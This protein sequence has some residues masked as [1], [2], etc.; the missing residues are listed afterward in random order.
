M[1]RTERIHVYHQ[2]PCQKWLSPGCHILSQSGYNKII[3]I[4]III[5]L[6]LPF[7]ISKCKD[8]GLPTLLNVNSRTS[9]VSNTKDGSTIYG[10]YAC[11][12]I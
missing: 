6:D 1:K 10:I 4:I 3:I 7:V 9:W 2:F 8:D 11:A 12:N 5:M